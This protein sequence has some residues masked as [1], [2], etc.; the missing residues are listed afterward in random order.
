MGSARVC[1]QHV[2]TVLIPVQSKRLMV[3]DCERAQASVPRL[4]LSDAFDGRST[5]PRNCERVALGAL[6]VI[7]RLSGSLLSRS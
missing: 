4:G 1:G 3:S 5:L 7:V 6:L 2:V